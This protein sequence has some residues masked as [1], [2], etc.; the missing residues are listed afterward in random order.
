MSGQTYNI[1]VNGLDGVTSAMRALPA[2]MANTAFVRV[3]KKI[4]ELILKAA[5][6]LVPVR[7]GFLRNALS[8][9]AKKMRDGKSFI[10][11]IG[12]LR[13]QPRIP[14]D[15]ITRGPNRGHTL[16]A[17]PSKYIHF[18]EMGTSTREATPFMRPAIAREAVN[19]VDLFTTE[20]EQE[21]DKAVLKVAYPPA[22]RPT[23]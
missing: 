22:P 6:E 8:S 5:K 20:I 23:S 18:V 17:V 13:G 7:F 2:E 15:T 10:C 14:I 12:V 1:S 11:A 19:A 3:V 9:R 16:Y 21:I 4:G